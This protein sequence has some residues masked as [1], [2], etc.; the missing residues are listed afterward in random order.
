MTDTPNDPHQ[1][2][3]GGGQR[4]SQAGRPRFD[5]LITLNTPYEQQFLTRL[6][7]H[8]AKSLEK[9]PERN[10]EQFTDLEAVQ[11][12]ESAAMRHIMQ[13]MSGDSSEDH[14]AA[15]VFNLMAAEHAKQQ[16]ERKVDEPW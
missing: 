5:L 15:V 6:A 4:E 16:M 2:F 3:P 13:W 14:A 9:Y 12:A 8:M 7:R 11:R 10:W 1:Q